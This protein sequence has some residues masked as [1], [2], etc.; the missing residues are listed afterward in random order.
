VRSS[1]SLHAALG[2]SERVVLIDPGQEERLRQGQAGD[3]AL[4]RP[5]ESVGTAR[6]ATG[7]KRIVEMAAVADRHLGSWIEI[8]APLHDD[9]GGA[10]GIVDDG[11]RGLDHGARSGTIN[12][13]GRRIFLC[14]CKGGAGYP[15]GDDRNTK[16]HEPHSPSPFHLTIY[17]VFPPQNQSPRSNSEAEVFA[18]LAP[19][20]LGRSRAEDQGSC[21]RLADTAQ[22]IAGNLLRPTSV[23]PPINE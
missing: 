9:G 23:I 10:V 18:K 17:P 20:Q 12:H 7:R 2:G 11:A 6:V 15:D 4:V 5:I 19:F 22:R 8:R 3:T 14:F 16:R 13:R 1:T 21:E